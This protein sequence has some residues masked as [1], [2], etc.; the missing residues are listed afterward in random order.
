MSKYFKL[1]AGIP[2]KEQTSWW[3][4]I[5]RKKHRDRISDE[6]CEQV[7]DFFLSPEV[8]RECPCKREAIK[9]KETKTIIQKNIMVLT[10][11]EA[12][13]KYV[14]SVTKILSLNR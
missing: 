3:K 10:M 13:H 9:D 6:L 5:K 11:Q 2:K 4:N 12:V 14:V 1:K 8:S 7:K